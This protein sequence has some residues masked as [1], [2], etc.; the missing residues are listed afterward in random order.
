[1]PPLETRRW[2]ADIGP[3]VKQ[4]PDTMQEEHVDDTIIHRLAD[5]IGEVA[6][7]LEYARPRS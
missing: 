4:L 7:G 2:L 1:M 5:W 3:V 6:D